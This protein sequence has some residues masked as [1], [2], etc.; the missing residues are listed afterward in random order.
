[1]NSI[2][3]PRLIKSSEDDRK[4][5]VME[6]SF[7]ILMNPGIYVL[8]DPIVI[9]SMNSSTITIE[10]IKKHN[11]DDNENNKRPSSNDCTF[12]ARDHSS[13]NSVR[14]A[15]KNN[16]AKFLRRFCRSNSV[17]QTQV[18]QQLE[19][20]DLLDFSGLIPSVC[21]PSH[22]TLVM[23]TDRRNIPVIRVTRGKL[24][25][26]RINL[27]HNCGG[28]D[29]WNGNTALQIQPP[30]DCNGHPIRTISSSLRPTAILSEV[31]M[32][33]LSG[34]GMVSIDGGNLV[35]KRC[36]VSNCAATGVYVGGPGS[37]AYVEQTDVICNG[38][39]DKQRRHG[40]SRGHSGVYL[41]Q[42]TAV[43]RE[44]NV[45]N[46]SLTG[47]SAVSHHNAFL[48]VESSDITGNGTIQLEMPPIGSMSR[49]KSSSDQNYIS[50]IG[51]GRNRSGLNQ[52]DTHTSIN[53]NIDESSQDITEFNTSL[54]NNTHSEDIPHVI[55]I[56]QEENAVD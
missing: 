22:A 23:N 29:I 48:T 16:S 3:N 50:Q 12:F 30:L 51:C 46:N 24:Y 13:N 43:L 52:E 25:M 17:I 10:T 55:P 42:G 54:D 27:L 34:R 11:L 6:S 5:K 47:I 7:R 39:G 36:F 19:N 32:S 45:S 4:F 18:S 20:H 38:H 35:S 28:T 41:E 44:C 2:N 37:S 56:S 33:S 14:K 31:A 53:E 9:N 40:V 49:E 21:Q 26:S 1:M 8:S 15:R